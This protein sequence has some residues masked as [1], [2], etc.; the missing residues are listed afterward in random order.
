MKQVIQTLVRSNMLTLLLMYIKDNIV[1]ITNL[2]TLKKI[3]MKIVAIRC[4]DKSV[5]NEI[6]CKYYN[7]GIWHRDQNNIDL[8]VAIN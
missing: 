7:H 8:P 4:L 3:A 5:T 6:P 1:C 2:C